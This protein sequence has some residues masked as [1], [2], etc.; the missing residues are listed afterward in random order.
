MASQVLISLSKV[1]MYEAITAILAT[2]RLLASFTPNVTVE[3][4]LLELHRLWR[5]MQRGAKLLS[6]GLEVS[7]HLYRH[8]QQKN[9]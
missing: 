3:H 5:W 6:K 2:G 9:S 8:G 1:A 7:L 4:I